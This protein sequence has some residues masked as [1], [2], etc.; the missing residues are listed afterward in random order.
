MDQLNAE[1]QEFLEEVIVEWIRTAEER[2]AG[3]E[4]AVKN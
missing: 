2:E 1:K 3:Y 4:V